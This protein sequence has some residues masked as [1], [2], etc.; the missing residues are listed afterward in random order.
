MCVQGHIAR[1]KFFTEENYEH[2]LIK[3]K[4]SKHVILPYRISNA[5]QAKESICCYIQS[6]ILDAFCMLSRKFYK[7][8]FLEI[9][10]GI[11][12]GRKHA[13][14]LLSWLWTKYCE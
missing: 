6:M 14:Q 3:K 7:I 9:E 11:S 12:F 13:I 2:K 5:L 4:A 1:K 8:Q 10:F